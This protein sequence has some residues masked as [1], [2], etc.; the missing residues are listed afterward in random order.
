MFDIYQPCPVAIGDWEADQP[1]GIL[2]ARDM[3]RAIRALGV[4][5][6]GAM[7]EL[8]ALWCG[9]SAPDYPLDRPG[10]RCRI[11]ACCSSEFCMEC[12]Q[13]RHIVFLGATP[14]LQAEINERFDRRLAELAARRRAG[15]GYAPPG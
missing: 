15:L 9:G 7:K 6:E 11:G 8:M 13:L 2:W 14:A 4:P 1:P 10:A 12:E 3:I 5:P